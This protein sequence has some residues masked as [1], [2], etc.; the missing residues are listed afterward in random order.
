M[1]T[2]TNSSNHRWSLILAG[3]EGQRTRP[4]VEQWLGY[5]KPK[6]FCSFVGT[7]SMLQHTW[8]RA[9][10]LTPCN[11]KVTVVSR[12]HHRHL[13]DHVD[14]QAAG[15]VLF[16][17]SNRDTAAGIFLPLTYI[18]K[19]QPNATVV[20]HPSDHFVY[21]EHRFI[22]VVRRAI[23]TAERLADRIILVGVQPTHMELE[24]GWIHPGPSLGYSGGVPVQGV[25]AFV[26][27]PSLSEGLTAFRNGAMWNTLVFAAKV[28]ALWA[29][30]HQAFPDLMGCFEELD[31]AI[32]T[33]QEGMVLE[34]LYKVVPE[35][36]FSSD[37]LQ[38]FPQNV[39]VIELQDTI[40]SDWGQPE[41]ILTT[42]EAIG[43]EP[44]FPQELV[45]L[46]M[47]YQTAS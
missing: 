31:R 18:R 36:N 29:L 33:S 17:P 6:Q 11:Q 38:K 19:W 5:H 22:D 40:W 35:Y 12:D 8:D 47:A 46:Q 27:K 32:G 43:K 13:W 28:E 14:S 7:R 26:E 34:A 45:R 44:A 10:R 21:P 39:G 37:L 1:S 20:A 41:R 15:K 16:Q 3:G 30:G 4:F 23:W 42:L 9:D 25:E 2:H 24:Y